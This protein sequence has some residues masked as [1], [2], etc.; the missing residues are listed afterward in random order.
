MTMRYV[1]IALIGL[2]A[3]LQNRLWFGTNTLPEYWQLQE[4]IAAQT[5]MNEVL[6]ARNQA[7]RYE[8]TDLKENLSS[9]EEH[10]RVDLGLIKP[11][12][13]FYRILTHD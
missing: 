10:A 8:T 4:K 5:T 13:T 3:I 11:N 12:E 1:F 2:L 7:L 9:I 6:E